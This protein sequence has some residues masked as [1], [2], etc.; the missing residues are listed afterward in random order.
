MPLTFP[1]TLLL[2]LTLLIRPLGS[3]AHRHISACPVS[4][5]SSQPPSP[6]GSS[7]HPLQHCLPSFSK[8]FLRV[9][10]P[11]TSLTPLLLPLTPSSCPGSLLFLVHLEGGRGDTCSCLI[12]IRVGRHQGTHNPGLEAH[13]T[14]TEVLSRLA[15]LC[16]IPWVSLYLT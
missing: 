1:S 8:A 9:G 3:V 14:V 2:S 11:P 13:F 15:Q 5:S 6:G 10:G 4:P 16:G 12:F 7:K